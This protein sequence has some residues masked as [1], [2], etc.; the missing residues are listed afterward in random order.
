MRSLGR[1]W[2]GF[3]LDD[4]KPYVIKHDETLSHQTIKNV[5]FSATRP[6]FDAHKLDISDEFQQVM[7]D[8]GVFVDTK[9]RGAV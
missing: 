5:F 4:D 8:W 7:E 1:T 3:L 2:A 6:R 9:H